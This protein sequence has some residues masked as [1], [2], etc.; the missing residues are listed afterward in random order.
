MPSLEPDDSVQDLTKWERFPQDWRKLV[1]RFRKDRRDSTGCDS[2]TDSGGFSKQGEQGKR[3]TQRVR[4]GVRRSRSVSLQRKA[5]LGAA[6]QSQHGM[7]PSQKL[8]K[9]LLTAVKGIGSLR[10]SY[11]F[12]GGSIYFGMLLFVAGAM[13]WALPLFYLMFCVVCLPQR[14]LVFHR[15][16][17]TF[18]MIDFCYF[19]NVAAAFALVF[20]PINSQVQTMVYAL[21]DGPV[22]G[23][24]LV[25]Q[26]A[27]VFGIW[28]HA[29]SV[30]IHLLPGL[31][32][33]AQRY[34]D[35]PRGL[36][37]IYESMKCIAVSSI[38]VRNPEDLYSILQCNRSIQA[39]SP[40]T[41]YT[42]D[43]LLWYFIAPMVF[44]IVW[45]FIYWL[46]VQVIFRDLILRKGYDTSYSALA[47]R[48][49]KSNSFWNRF[50]RRGSL[51]RRVA[52][53]GALQL[54]FMLVMFVGFIPVY[55]SFALGLLWQIIKVVVPLY[56]GS[57]YQ[58][59]RLPK[60]LLTKAL[61]EVN[62]RQAMGETRQTQTAVCDG[63]CVADVNKQQKENTE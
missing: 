15:R 58:C 63:V 9:E 41:P 36:G 5:S 22:A 20:M 40:Y 60:Y 1:Q 17:W 44:Y 50:V 18:F 12:A 33:F 62:R 31:A 7:E 42:Q 3:S 10:N 32:M 61:Q 56:Y 27:W 24:L 6:R 53:Y 37:E 51:A 39:D 55:K 52:L 54:V 4:S 11:L 8:L 16:K 46:I 57:R 43:T 29:V 23:A 14:A 34:F 35:A 26:C 48:A 2:S 47:R 28:D 49:A 13:P 19:V 30:L 21:A 25:W 45:Q 59:E 38:K